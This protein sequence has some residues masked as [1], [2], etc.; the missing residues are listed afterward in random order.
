MGDGGSVRFWEERWVR[1]ECLKQKFKR[2]YDMSVQ[3]N[4]LVA[5]LGE[6]GVEGRV[7]KL[8]WRRNLFAHEQQILDNLM[9]V[10][11]SVQIQRNV[12]DS[13][14][15]NSDPERRYS[16][17][18]AYL[19]QFT[20]EDSNCFFKEVWRGLVPS[21]V[22]CH[23]WRVAHG[24]L[25]TLDNLI[26]RG[27]DVDNSRSGNCFLCSQQLENVSHLFFGCKFSYKIWMSCYAWLGI[28][29]VLPVDYNTHFM[30]N[31]NWGKNRKQRLCWRTIWLAVIWSIWIHRNAVVFKR[32]QLNLEELV[33]Q[34]KLRSWLWLKSLLQSFKSSFYEWITEPQICMMGN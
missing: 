3:K 10:L 18:S 34:V 17:K 23:A 26:Q 8:R 6:W 19:D 30:Q 24:R 28:K 20:H 1:G 2:L 5:E 27:V 16:V 25:P 31:E 14:Q 33:E 12:K 32:E 4:C 13:W 9:Q 7:W 29:T 21:K 11:S 15:W 22:A